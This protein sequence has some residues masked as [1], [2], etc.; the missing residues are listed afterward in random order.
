MIDINELLAEVTA[1][2]ILAKFLDALEALGVP[3]KSWRAGG[4]YRT[5][6]RVVAIT[7]ASFVAIMRLFIGA[8]FLETATGTFLTAMALSVYGVTRIPAT[9]ATG[10]VTL[11]NAGGGVFLLGIGELVVK[12]STTGKSFTNT[13]SIS[14][15]A[16]DTVGVDI[17]ALEIGSASS[18]PA[19]TIDT[20]VTSL[21]SVTCSNA[22]AVI[23]SDEELDADLR[24]RCLARLGVLGGKGPRSAYEYAIRSATRIDG[25]PVD[26]NRFSLTPSTTTGVITIY[27]A[28]PSG[29]P[30]AADV[31]AVADS[32][33]ALA[34][35]DTVTATT[36][37]ASPVAL[38]DSLT[39]WARK[40]AAA[41]LDA[42]G[43]QALVEAAL[44]AMIRDYPIGGLAKTPA[45]TYYLFGS[46][47]V[48]AAQS[49]HVSIYA[50]DGA[51]DHV[52]TAGQVA[53]LSATIDVRLV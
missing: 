24:A 15:G 42:A 10:T 46:E 13:A 26:I 11:V 25:S 29:A 50:V 28:S 38:T 2:E 47:T 52:L 40:S 44:E 8:G 9:F 53:T 30:V 18:A 5:I 19:T 6:L 3:A 4:V 27:V 32:I 48:G 17:Q 51:V 22:A 33:E 34:R 12:S 1:D 39:V 16:G 7:Y 45:T 20:L 35:P 49:A 14:L 23:G 41:G 43:L 36:L 21:P 31:T 37:A